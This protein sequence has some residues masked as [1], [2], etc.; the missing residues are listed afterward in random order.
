MTTS[1]EHFENII[2]KWVQVDN[3]IKIENDNLKQLR[4]KK[5]IINDEIINYA[6][7]NNLLK[8]NIELN[9]SRLKFVNSKITQPITFKY[10]EKCLNDLI[11][12]NNKVNEI[13]NYL[14]QNRENSTVIEI[15]RIH[16]N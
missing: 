5:N 7:N 11:Q 8:A 3:Q 1:T 14:K 15:K 10:I 2:K 4:N 13:I 16:N 6:S 12:D 9:D